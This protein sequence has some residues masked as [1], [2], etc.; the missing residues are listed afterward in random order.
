VLD[1]CPASIVPKLRGNLLISVALMRAA[2]KAA[3]QRL[4]R[5]RGWIFRALTADWDE[6]LHQHLAMIK[7]VQRSLT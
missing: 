3:Y 7:P 6:Q 1:P 2:M 4:R 5:R